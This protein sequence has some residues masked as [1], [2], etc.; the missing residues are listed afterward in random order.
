MPKL[1]TRKSV[2]KRF[3]ITATGKVKHYRSGK[4]HILTK[5]NSKRKRRLAKSKILE[6]AQ[7]KMIKKMLPYS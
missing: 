3:K 4:S 2:A 5:K 1:K 6:G 7:A